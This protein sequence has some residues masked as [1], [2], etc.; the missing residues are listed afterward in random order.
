MPQRRARETIAG[1]L[2]GS[3]GVTVR[4][5]AELYRAGFRVLPSDNARH[6]P[7]WAVEPLPNWTKR[8]LVGDASRFEGVRFLLTFRP[9]SALPAAVRSGYLEGRIELLPS[10]ITLLFWGMP[11]YNAASRQHPLAIQFP[12]LRLVPRHEGLGLRVPQFGWLRHKRNDAVEA[13]DDDIVVNEYARTHRWERLPRD[14]D[15]VPKRQKVSSVTTTLFSTELADLDLYHKPMAR[16]A[17]IWTR[18]GELILDG[19]IASRADIKR[20]AARVLAGGAFL[21]VFRFPAMR[22]GT[23]EVFWQRPLAACAFP[24][25]GVTQLLDVELP[26]YRHRVRSRTQRLRTAGGAVSAD[27]AAAAL[28]R[29]A[30]PDR[31]L[32]GLLPVS[33]ESERSERPRHGAAVGRSPAARICRADAARGAGSAE[34]RAVARHRRAALRHA[35]RGRGIETGTD[36]VHRTAASSPLAESA[37]VR[38]DGDARVR[39]SVLAPPRHAVARRVRQQSERRRGRRHIDARTRRARDAAIC[40]RSANF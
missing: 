11:I 33:D 36:E 26:G 32:E 19:P 14:E 27:T 9:F 30:V 28:R 15:P 10:P 13:G 37:D 25:R 34:H 40:T 1:L 35:R 38:R 12:V 20:A 3:F 29:R 16:N 24:D 8:Y 7:Q 18:H 17:Q 23:H 4:D 31:P 5:A 2:A 22:V 39:G 21:Y 6:H